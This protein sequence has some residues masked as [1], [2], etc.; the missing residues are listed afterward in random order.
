MALLALPEPYDFELST[1]RYRAF[2]LD[3]ANLWREGGLHRVVGGREVRIVEADGGVD[4]EPTAPEFD[5]VV[6][7]QHGAELDKDAL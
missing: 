4:N 5:P 2:G 3:L 1:E 7:K 6:R